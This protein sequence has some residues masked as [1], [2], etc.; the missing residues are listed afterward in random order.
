M[1]FL[2]CDK[3][4]PCLVSAT[5]PLP[6]ISKDR[7]KSRRNRKESTTTTNRKIN[8]TSEV[9][10]LFLANN[11]NKELQKQISHVIPDMSIGIALVS[12]GNC[13]SLFKRMIH[14]VAT[15]ELSAEFPIQH[16]VY[17][18]R[19]K[20][21]IS[22][23][24]S[25]NY[26]SSA[27]EGVDFNNEDLILDVDIQKRTA[28]LVAVICSSSRYTTTNNDDD[29]VPIV[30]E[31]DDDD[32]TTTTADSRDMDDSNESMEEDINSTAS[33]SNDDISTTSTTSTSE[34][35]NIDDTRFG[36]LILL[37]V[38]ERI[39]V[40]RRIPLPFEVSC[41]VH[42]DTYFNKILVGGPLGQLALIN[43]NTGKLIHLFQCILP[44]AIMKQ[45]RNNDSGIIAVSE[46]DDE[47]DNENFASSNI[48]VV[49]Q[50]PAVDTVAVG[51][52]G[53]KV[54]LINLKFDTVLF[55]LEH[56][57][58]Y[59]ISKKKDKVLFPKRSMRADRIGITS[60]TFRTDGF[61]SAAHIAPLAV[62]RTDGTISIWDLNT[63]EENPHRR[64]LHE[65]EH[66]HKGG[67]AK[68]TFLPL[69]PI[70]ISSGLQ[71]NCIAMH[72]FD[73]PN[74][75]SRVLRHRI[76]H[77]SP[78]SFIR[79]IHPAIGAVIGDSKADGTDAANCSILSG[80][81]TD[82]TLRLFSTARTVLD[83]EWSQG[84]GL[85]K[86]AKEYGID[87]RD[88]L[89]P[90]IT[91]FATSEARSRDF[92]DTVSIHQ[93]HA[94]AYVWSSRKGAQSGP[95]LRQDD[96]NISAMKKQPPEECHASAVT[97]SA[98]GH[99]CLV[100][101]KGGIIYKYNIQS[102]LP[103]GSYPQSE[104]NEK[105]RKNL[106]IPGSLSRTI[107][108]M[109]GKMKLSAPANLDKKDA[110]EEQQQLAEQ[111]RKARS[112]LARH[113]ATVVGLAVDSL[114]KTLMS[115]GSDGVL[116]VWAFK[117]HAPHKKSPINLSLSGATK[118][119][120]MPESDLAAIALKDFSIVVLDCASLS[121]VRRLGNVSAGL[122]AT[123]HSG[124]ISD[125]GFGP[126]GRR[127]FTSVSA[128]NHSNRFTLFPI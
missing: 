14:P 113:T 42:P 27:V 90:P 35:G 23:C 84:K 102:G 50:S 66:F 47:D 93:N 125:M 88:L 63:T 7:I 18:G 11:H 119:C 101:T 98:C 104:S 80:G 38:R 46:D 103:R 115:V 54:H 73:S 112:L 78:P 65:I 6:L 36:E 55:T 53:G 60:L 105:T 76:G 122:G 100:G 13:V 110:E 94:P 58:T 77:A 48:T 64:L 114:N 116:L 28:M 4:A 82:R 9:D 43:V 10:S 37:R 15:I 68:C 70:L 85:E 26:E 44:R 74:N 95:V 5:V 97:I 120:H 75:T 69:E 3:L 39:E 111:A 62:G 30:G 52:A 91:M 24:A 79:Y 81:S 33:R 127:L 106:N 32:D 16:M 61:A 126:D 117:T 2:Q 96:W 57:F 71:D 25:T 128:K 56:D 86:R 83:R 45:Q 118:L 87:K 22:S 17:M 34:V 124:P 41:A 12:H 72:V 123:R 59:N 1:L 89:L 92:G 8:L 40:I 99:Y 21:D 19:T 109:E 20:Q 107:R 49:T 108:V 67:V 31:D 121:V 51:T 29:K